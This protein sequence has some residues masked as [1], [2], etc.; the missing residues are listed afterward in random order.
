MPIRQSKRSAETTTRVC[1]LDRQA[2]DRLPTATVPIPSAETPTTETKRHRVHLDPPLHL[3]EMANI[4]DEQPQKSCKRDGW[5]KS[6]EQ[7]GRP[8][9]FCGL[10]QVPRYEI[11]DHPHCSNRY[12][13]PRSMY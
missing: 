8:I 2:A 10:E 12:G 11:R 4:P 3:I 9:E 6:D 13:E 5:R 1:K 7:T